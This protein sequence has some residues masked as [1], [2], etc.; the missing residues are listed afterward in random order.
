VS[1]QPQ[2][3]KKIRKTQKKNGNASLPFVNLHLYDVFGPKQA[4]IVNSGALF[5]DQGFWDNFLSFVRFWKT[6][7]M[8]GRNSDFAYIGRGFAP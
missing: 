8:V 4:T 3:Q 6:D 1:E 2:S 7:G 5:D